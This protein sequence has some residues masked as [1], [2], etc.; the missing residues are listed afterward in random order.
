[1]SLNSGARTPPG[2]IVVE[3]V[4]AYMQSPLYVCFCHFDFLFT[5]LVHVFHFMFRSLR[6]TS[7][8]FLYPVVQFSYLALF[9]PF[10]FAPSHLR[11]LKEELS[12]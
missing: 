1:M 9:N 3:T 4:S 10:L 2:L 11:F 7:Y 6:F 12:F 8:Y 5:S